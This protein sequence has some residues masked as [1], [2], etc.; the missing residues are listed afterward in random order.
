MVGF[1]LG[2]ERYFNRADVGVESHFGIGGPWDS[3]ALDGAIFQWI[4]TDHTADA[5]Y[6]ANPIA[7]SIETSDGGDPSRPWSI[8]QGAALVRLINRLCNVYD[9]PRRQANSPTGSGIGWH[10]MWG[11][12]SEWTPVSG[13][14]CPGSVR[15]RQLKTEIYPKVFANQPA[16]DPG[17]WF[18]DVS[19]EGDLRGAVSA[20]LDERFGGATIVLG[21]RNVGGNTAVAADQAI[22]ANERLATLEA[23]INEILVLLKE[24]TVPTA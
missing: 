17:R 13:K 16:N 10:A 8:K 22:K 1:L 21:Q 15:I 3:A 18:E 19:T 24:G 23:K 2:T 12:P 6:H 4:G 20:E 11:A 5:N 14:V 7:I 9:I